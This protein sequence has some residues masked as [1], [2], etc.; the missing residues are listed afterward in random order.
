MGWGELSAWLAALNR[1]R[2]PAEQDPHS[3][4]NTEHDPWWQDARAKRDAE[5]AD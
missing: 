1:E 2:M 4:K 3:W 5:R